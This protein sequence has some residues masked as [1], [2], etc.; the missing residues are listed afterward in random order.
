MVTVRRKIPRRGRVKLV[1]RLNKL[2]KQ[3]LRRAGSTGFPIVL[4][5]RF[6]RKGGPTRVLEAVLALLRRRPS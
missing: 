5:A 1:P 6:E 4:R 2:G 3:R